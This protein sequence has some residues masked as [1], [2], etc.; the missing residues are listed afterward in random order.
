MCPPILLTAARTGETSSPPAVLNTG[1]F[2]DPPEFTVLHDKGNEE[3]LFDRVDYQ[4]STADSVHLNSRLQPQLVPDAKF[5]RCR[6]RDALERTEWD[7][8]ASGKLWRHR[9]RT[10]VTVGP[11]DQRSKIGT[12]NFAPS[13]T[14]VL[15]TDAVFT[16]GAFVRRDDYNYYPSS[17]PFAD[18]GPP[19]LQ[20]QSVG[21][22]R[23][24]TNAGTSIRSLLCQRD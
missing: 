11:T 23:T 12:F 10:A 13:W 21:Q 4:F 3:N 20:R 6:K 8:A 22:N 24:L 15:N 16:L 5:A 18:L 2:L 19:S 14:H 9:L 1:R 17:D 7:S